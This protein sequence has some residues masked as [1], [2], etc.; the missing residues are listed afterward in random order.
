MRLRHN[1]A[2]YTSDL[3]LPHFCL[4]LSALLTVIA[5][6]FDR[7][8]IESVFAERLFVFVLG[9]FE[10]KRESLL[11][12]ANKVR[13]SGLAAEITID[14]LRVDVITAVDLSG[15]AIGGVC[16]VGARILTGGHV[17][18]FLA[19]F[20]ML[21][22]VAGASAQQATQSPREAAPTDTV[23]VT[24]TGRAVLTPDRFTFN[25]G[26][27]TTGQSVDEAVNEN[28]AKANAVIAALKKAGA[29]EQEIR[30]SGFTI[31][32][33]QDY[34]QGHLPKLLGYQVS[35]N[36]TITKKQ[37][38]DAGKL[39]Q[40]A[41]SAGVNQASGI[42][43]EVS[44]PTRG[45]DEGMRAAFN[46]AKAKATLLATV[47]GRTLGQAIAITEG[48]AGNEMPRPMLRGVVAQAARVESEVPI[49]GGTQELS[50]TVSVVFALR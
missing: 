44:D 29:T 40:V 33:Q 31:Y 18:R 14:A 21:I 35:N 43:F 23:S 10:N 1:D 7:T 37:I 49:E 11:V 16:H 19:I 46:E 17:N 22:V 5:D 20:I 6:R 42:T 24:G 47:A 45:R 9:L 12:I 8:I 3:A 38:A 4:L 15:N 30:T 32:P 13:G 27:Q 39:L 50:F 26:V 25:V 28:N 41:V 34:S 2:A 48:T 36:I